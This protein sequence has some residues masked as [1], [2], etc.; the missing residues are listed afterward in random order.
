MVA[1]TYSKT[2]FSSFLSWPICVSVSMARAWIYWVLSCGGGV[3]LFACILT[4]MLP[5][6]NRAGSCSARALRSTGAK[7]GS[8]GGISCPSAIVISSLQSISAPHCISSCCYVVSS[9]LLL[10]RIG[11][12]LQVDQKNSPPTFF[13]YTKD[14]YTQQ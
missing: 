10:I 9:N 5:M 2:P 8:A 6:F 1:F 12:M 4:V 14:F 7:V 13:F 11:I 3:K